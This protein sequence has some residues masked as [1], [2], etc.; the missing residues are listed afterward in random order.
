[1]G[2]ECSRTLQREAGILAVKISEKYADEM[3][4]RSTKIRMCDQRIQRHVQREGKAKIICCFQSCPWNLRNAWLK[5]YLLLC[6]ICNFEVMRIIILKIYV[7][8]FT[9][10]GLK[11]WLH[12]VW[13]TGPD[14]DPSCSTPKGSPTQRRRHNLSCMISYA[15]GA[16]RV[17][18]F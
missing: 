17:L 12:V 5:L 3:G 4:Y 13:S 15:S 8:I 6:W 16:E 1:M 10:H 7:C 2:A 18:P 9:R 11:L 14:H